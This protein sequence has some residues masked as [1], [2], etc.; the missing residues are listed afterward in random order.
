MSDEYILP[1]D[2]DED[3]PTPEPAE[4]RRR[5]D[6][7]PAR[8]PAVV[9]PP[10]DN[11]VDAARIAP[12]DPSESIMDGVPSSVQAALGE[13]GLLVLKNYLIESNMPY[14]VFS[15]YYCEMASK[16]YDK[17]R[18]LLVPDLK[19]W[20]GPVLSA[21]VPSSDTPSQTK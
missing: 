11:R 4:K 3:E 1:M 14:T 19:A 21:L 5:F 7:P 2:D 16:N 18:S 9:R 10:G 13:D 15:D 8:G 17:A 20:A 6:K 12:V